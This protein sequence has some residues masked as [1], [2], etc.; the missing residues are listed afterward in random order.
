[1]SEAGRV[2]TPIDAFLLDELQR[3]Q[4]SFSPDADKRALIRRAYLDLLGLP[5]TYEAVDALLTND[6]PDAWERL[7]DELLESPHYGE[8]WAR[9]WLDV[10]GY[11]DSEGDAE[12]DRVRAFAYKYRD[13]VIRSLNGDKPF[14][15]F[16][17]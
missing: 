3:R 7:V 12:G 15:Q 16:I 11:A 5:P 1:M 6:A 4:L 14:D 13:Y 8:R 2:R 17:Q 9:H 10:A